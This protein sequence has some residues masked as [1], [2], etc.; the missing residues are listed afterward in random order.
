MLEPVTVCTDTVPPDFCTKCNAQIRLFE[1]FFD[2][3]SNSVADLGFWRSH[4]ERILGPLLL[5]FFSLFFISND[6]NVGRNIEVCNFFE[7]GNKICNMGK[8]L[9]MSL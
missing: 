9:Q 5:N 8:V 3:I 4:T 1:Q 7:C 6:N 2:I